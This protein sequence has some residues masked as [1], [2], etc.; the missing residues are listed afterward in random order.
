M[1]HT[2][3][4]RRF[5]ELYTVSQGKNTCLDLSQVFSGLSQKVVSGGLSWLVSGDLS[6]T[7]LRRLVSAR[8]I[9]N[10]SEAARRS[11]RGILMGNVF[12]ESLFSRCVPGRYLRTKSLC[13]GCSRLAG[14]RASGSCW[15]MCDLSLTCR[16][17]CL[18]LS[19][20]L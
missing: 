14:L 9:F 4:A 5:P 7:C 13:S 6:L 11:A 2:N 10:H 12:P 17:T 20:V 16:R 3:H 15:P 8:S 1:T 19:Q 18:D